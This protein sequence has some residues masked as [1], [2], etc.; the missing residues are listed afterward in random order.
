ML[1]FAMLF[2]IYKNESFSRGLSD[3]LDRFLKAVEREDEQRALYYAYVAG[4]FLNSKDRI[5][6]MIQRQS[7][8]RNKY[9]IQKWV[10][11]YRRYNESEYDWI[12]RMRTS[13]PVE[14]RFLTQDKGRTWKVMR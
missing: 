5:L 10:E 3:Y 14:L 9:L 12:R 7:A 2:D 4:I 1:S 13:Q 8:R 6:S 11:E